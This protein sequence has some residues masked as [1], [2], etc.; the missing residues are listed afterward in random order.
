MRGKFNDLTGSVFG[1]LTVIEQAPKV[2][3]RTA[4]KCACTCGNTVAVMARS[5][6]SGNTRSCGCLHSEQLKERFT[7]H[8]ERWTRLY[9]IWLAMRARCRNSQNTAYKHYGAR[10][11][12]VCAE[13]D[14]SY[15]CFRSW[16]LSHGYDDSLSIDRIDVDGNYC[17]E[18]CRWV[19]WDTQCYNKTNTRYLTYKGETKP[20]GTWARLKGMSRNT[21]RSRLDFLGWSVEKALETPVQAHR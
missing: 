9:H 19:D 18:N 21:L 13:W 20:L 8:G 1:R 17:P 15:S 2:N 16:A 3:G 7:K 6:L 4:F 14:R 5:L 11:I 12:S 10:G